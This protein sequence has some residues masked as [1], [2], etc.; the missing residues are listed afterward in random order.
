MMGVEAPS[1]HHTP[2]AVMFSEET[3][4]NSKII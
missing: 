4:G 2:L 1:L 3:T